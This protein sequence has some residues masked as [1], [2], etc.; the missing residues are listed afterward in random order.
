MQTEKNRKVVLAEKMMLFTLIDEYELS[1]NN[2]E[3]GHKDELFF[4]VAA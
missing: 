2:I 4:F 1:N 3:I